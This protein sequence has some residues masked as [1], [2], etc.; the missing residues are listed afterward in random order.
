M[1]MF[2]DSP[3]ILLVVSQF[4]FCLGQS[5]G[6]I[7]LVS[8]DNSYYGRLDIFLNGRWGTF[9]FSS[10]YASMAYAACRQLGFY[11]YRGAYAFNDPLLAVHTTST[12]VVPRASDSMPIALGDSQCE[13][14]RFL[15]VLRCAYS[16]VRPSCTHDND[17]ILEC[18]ETS[19][20]F[21]DPAYNTQLRLQSDTFPSTGTL[22]IFIS[23]EWGNV[24]FD[25]FD[26]GAAN[27]ACRQLGYTNAKAFKSTKAHIASRDW[28]SGVQCTSRSYNCLNRC[29]NQSTFPSASCLNGD[30][31]SLQCTFVL[32]VASVMT[33]GSRIECSLNYVLPPTEPEPPT[34][35]TPDTVPVPGHGGRITTGTGCNP[36]DTLDCNNDT[37]NS[38]A[39]FAVYAVF[40]VP[41]VAVVLIVVIFCVIVCVVRKKRNRGQYRQPFCDACCDP[42]CNRR[43]PVYNII[44]HP[45]YHH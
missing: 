33:S 20:W 17:L 30:H 40:L 18:D 12:A 21:D 13:S 2:V 38:H 14:S 31:V 35:S 28:L 4:S 6:D 3:L 24:C 5:E 36:Y 19:L 7:R 42:C 1:K 34:I 39:V 11:N 32:S 15:H 22:Q 29:F 27:S 44:H 10:D 43:R 37:G 41:I 23:R 26:Q 25:Q 9:C 16:Q 45:D 8:S